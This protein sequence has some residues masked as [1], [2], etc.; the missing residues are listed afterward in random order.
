MRRFISWAFLLGMIPFLTQCLNI[1]ELSSNSLSFTSTQSSAPEG[2]DVTVQV[3]LDRATRLD[4]EVEFE[5]FFTGS[6]F[7]DAE[8]TTPS[9][10]LIEA[11]QRVGNIT[12][13]TQ[14]DGV[15]E[16]NGDTLTLVITGTNDPD[17]ILVE[18]ALEFQHI[19]T[20]NDV[21]E[22]P[23]TGVRVYLTWDA[24][25]Q[26]FNDA[27]LDLILSYDNGTSID[28]ILISESSQGFEDVG[29]AG[30]AADGDYYLSVRYLQTRNNLQNDVEFSMV[31]A[32]EDGTLSFAESAL[33]V[34]Q[35][36]QTIPFIKMNK[37]GTDFTYSFAE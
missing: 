22:L 19:I 18:D 30:T 31:F 21:P 37:V 3:T 8:L 35:V 32:Q 17:L 28:P 13:T 26:S 11:G 4:L 5:V 6:Y 2:T 29:L 33:T 9:P 25:T 34:N 20:D 16:L 12:F 14:D 10:L 1:P 23:S 7:Y 24:A 27:D 15:M 36:G